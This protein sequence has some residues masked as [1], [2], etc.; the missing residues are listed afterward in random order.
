MGHVGVD[1]EGPG[2]AQRARGAAP[3]WL[4]R[5][6][7]S[8]P[9]PIGWSQLARAAVA[10]SIPVA[11]GALLG[12]IEWG[13]LASTG[14][15]PS[16]TGD[17]VGAYRS[18]AQRLA[19]ALGAAVL[20]FGLGLATGGQAPLSVGLVILVAAAS[21]LISDAGSNAS[22]AAL[23][24]FVFTVLG[25]GLAA[26]GTPIGLGLA[27][28]AVGSV[29]G[30]F[31]ALVGWPVR[32]TT[33]ERRAVAQV[34]LE[35][36]AM[37]SA[38]SAGDE[39]TTLAARQQLTRALNVAYDRLLV[40]RSWLS[41]RDSTYRRLLNLLAAG[42]PAVEASV[43]AVDQG[44]R[45]PDAVIAY[46]TDLAAAVLS[47]TP[48]PEV[49]ALPEPGRAGV[50][51]SP[52]V[53][54]L[55]TALGGISPERERLPRDRVPVRRRVRDWAGTL[56]SGPLTWLAAARLTV[57]VAL[58][59]LTRV[60]IPTDRSYWITLTVGLVLKPDFGSVFGRA[61]LR[62]LGTVAGVGIGVLA[63]AVVPHGLPL[64]LL[65][66]VFGA[67]V[68]YGK[69]RHFGVMS[70]FVTPLIL[71]QMVLSAGDDEVALVRLEDTV[72]GC[73]LVLVFG[74]LLWP[75][76]RTP[77]LGGRLADVA[78]SISRYAEYALRPAEDPA[79]RTERS[80]A[81]RR[82]YRGLSDVRTAFQ[83][84]VVEPSAAGRQAVAWWP[85]I[86][87]LE[88]LTDA[89]TAVA[90]ALDQHAAEAP[91][92]A[93]VRRVRAGL[94]EFSL[95]VRTGSEPHTVDLPGEELLSSVRAQ[96]ASALEAVDGPDLRTFRHVR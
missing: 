67:G 30:W 23:Q 63:L 90:V 68:A 89:I 13:A 48:L 54:A 57:C 61:I 2:G 87:A 69:G 4:V 85:A 81:R 8:T 43:A 10:L 25:T 18:R 17:V 27:C 82:A 71:V 75:G 66:A 78:E 21:A 96:L 38:V 33:P 40:A 15:L 46:F 80:R 94:A 29:W 31:V 37:L 76:S 41:G 12:E 7:R 28:F 32:P 14:A 22:I 86:V 9:A 20:G 53:T 55:V 1:S 11:V 19:G 5:L 45:P 34:Y 16:V 95:C 49:P 6:L 65:V 51:T 3:R 39:E 64:A 84:L 47:D 59:E 83:Q 50:E 52:A 24:L 35:L 56:A 73:A 44:V 26:E 36:A 93:G 62:G 88:Q 74:Y 77:V 70:A 42:T 58:A 60:L 72:I 91:E 79:A 92:D